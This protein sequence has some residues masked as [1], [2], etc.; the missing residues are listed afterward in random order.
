MSAPETNPV[1]DPAALQSKAE[2]QAVQPG[3]KSP[4]GTLDPKNTFVSNLSQL[5]E[6]DPKVYQAT[7]KSIAQNIINAMKRHQDRFKKLMRESRR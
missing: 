6:L 5:K 2:V 4:E 1:E 7:M 3:V